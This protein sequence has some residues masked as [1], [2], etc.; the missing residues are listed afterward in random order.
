MT[1]TEEAL[2]QAQEVRPMIAQLMLGIMAMVMRTSDFQPA[3]PGPKRVTIPAEDSWWKPVVEVA[4]GG[5][6]VVIAVGAR[7]ALAYG[8]LN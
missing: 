3:G 4:M 2:E 1:V 5:V 7:L 8:W 6:I